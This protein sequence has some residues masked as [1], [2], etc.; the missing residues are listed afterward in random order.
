VNGGIQ[1]QG[2]YR[3]GGRLTAQV[4]RTQVF[5]KQMLAENGYSGMLRRNDSHSFTDLP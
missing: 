3:I 1:N 4:F 2:K 5:T